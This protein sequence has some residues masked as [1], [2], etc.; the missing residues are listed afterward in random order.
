MNSLTEEVESLTEERSTLNE[1]KEVAEKEVMELKNDL[2]QLNSEVSIWYIPALIYFSVT[3]SFTCLHQKRAPTDVL[4]FQLNSSKEEAKSAREEIEHAKE[5]GEKKLEDE[6]KL[7]EA[8]SKSHQVELQNKLDII[9]DLRNQITDLEAEKLANLPPD[10]QET[11]QTYRDRLTLLEQEV[12]GND[13]MKNKLELAVQLEKTKATSLQ[14]NNERLNQSLADVNVSSY[15]SF[16]SQVANIWIVQRYQL[17][18]LAIYHQ[19]SWAQNM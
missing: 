15:L 10:A 3:A 11:I 8:N 16:F 2:E 18:L 17:S 14:E 13:D 9:T 12:E 4:I 1:E 19:F 6:K 7:A 5:E